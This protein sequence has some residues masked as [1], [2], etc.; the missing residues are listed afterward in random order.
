MTTL[1][2][3]SANNVLLNSLALPVPTIRL[4]A[5]PSPDEIPV[6]NSEANL[7]NSLVV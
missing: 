4:L 1:E 2:F 7:V 6:L 5:L 3:A